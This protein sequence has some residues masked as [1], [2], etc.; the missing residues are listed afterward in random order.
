MTGQILIVCVGNICRSPM[1]EALWNHRLQQLALPRQ[2]SSAG[3]SARFGDP[4]HPFAEQL[5]KQ[6][7][8]AV[9]T[10][11]SRPLSSALLRESEL[12]LVMERWHQADIERMAPYAR[13][14]IYLLGHWQTVEVP[15]PMGEPATAFQEAFELIDRGITEWLKR[16]HP[17]GRFRPAPSSPS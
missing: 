4:I 7:D 10:R 3:L 5:L 2:A 1:A 15:D 11:R 6:R 13:G 17:D 9:P 8:I 16:L 12:V 14:R